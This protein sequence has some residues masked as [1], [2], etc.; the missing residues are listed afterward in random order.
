MLR[1]FLCLPPIT[2]KKS[3]NMSLFFWVGIF[4]LR[5]SEE[6]S[7]DLFTSTIWGMAEED[8]DVIA[9]AEFSS[10]DRQRGERPT[11]A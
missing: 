11:F 7:V 10:P 1:L 6:V 9:P 3:Q 5:N 2:P 8:E 4:F